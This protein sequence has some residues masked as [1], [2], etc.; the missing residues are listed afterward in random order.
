MEK[1]VF[2][3]IDTTDVQKAKSWA[4]STSKYL[5][6]IKLGMEFFYSNGSEAVKEV[7]ENTINSNCKLFLDL[8]F[9]DIP[10]TVAGAVRAVTQLEPDFL[11]V[12]ALGGSDMIKAAVDTAN[13]YSDSINILA[14][15]ILTSMSSNDVESVGIDKDIK[16]EVCKL[17]ELALNAGAAGLV[18]SPLE[19][20]VLRQ[21]F[22]NNF[23][24][25]VP[26]IRPTSSK[27]ET[28]DQQRTMTPKQAIQTGADF[29]VMGRPITR[30]DDI[31]KASKEIATEIALA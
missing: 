16:T 14:V 11:T 30:A 18:C 10:N 22:G 13:S 1:D 27:L 2:V 25:V 15:T 29:L 17:A 19:I 31:E 28:D 9:H 7:I 6:G 12:H 23:I 3:A 21:N 20:S 26:G 8:K 24:L 5:G 4:K